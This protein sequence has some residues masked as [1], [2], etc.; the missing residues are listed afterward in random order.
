[1]FFS[2]RRRHTRFSRDW[3]SDVC[4]SDLY[5][6]YYVRTDCGTEQSLWAGPF[7]FYTGYCIP[8]STCPEDTSNRIYGF[9]TTDGYTNILNENNGVENAYSNY[10]NMSVTQSPGGTFYYNV[11]VP[12][13]TYVEIWIDLDQ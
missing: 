2:S 4:S 13:W 9:S 3:S 10:S 6:Q 5:Y 11:T 1:F 8:T 7:T 12:A